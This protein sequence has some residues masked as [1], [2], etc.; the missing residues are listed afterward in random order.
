MVCSSGICGGKSRCPYPAA[1]DRAPFNKGKRKKGLQYLGSGWSLVGCVDHDNNHRCHPRITSIRMGI[2]DPPCSNAISKQSSSDE[3]VNRIVRSDKQ[4][5]RNG[6][7]INR[8]EA[9]PC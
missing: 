4:Q 6:S 9:I 8:M 5:K 3:K 7:T 1:P 2:R